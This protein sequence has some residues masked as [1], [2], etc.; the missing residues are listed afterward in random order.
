MSVP[1]ATRPVGRTLFKYLAAAVLLAAVSVWLLAG[2]A[3]AETGLTVDVARNQNLLV[4]TATTVEGDTIVE[5]S[6]RW[7]KSDECSVETFS[8]DSAD[9]GSDFSVVIGQDDLGATYCFY[10]EDSAG[11]QAAGS[12]YVHYPKIAVRQNDDQLVAEVANMD[13]DG[14]DVDDSTWIWFRYQAAD[15]S[16]FGCEP[17]HFN[18]DDAGLMRAAEAAEGFQ[19]EMYGEVQV[20]VYELQRDVYRAGEG[21]TVSVTSADEGLNFCFQVADTAGIANSKLTTVGPVTVADATGSKPGGEAAD[22]VPVDDAGDIEGAGQAGADG[23]YSDGS[24]G[25]DDGGSGNAVRNIGLILLAGAVV[26]GIFML[27]K[28]SQNTGDEEEDTRA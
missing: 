10:A 23:S 6:W 20:D 25:S 18:L 1:S 24:E 17:Q 3:R 14:I 9:Y 26:I 15:D 11:R 19:T 5:D 8:D 2:Q 27:V 28:R 21:S 4:A 16:R 7:A 13:E 22:S 12:I